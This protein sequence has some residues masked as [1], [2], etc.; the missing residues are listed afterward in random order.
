MPFYEYRCEKCQNE[1]ENL[2]RSMNS[3]LPKCP[4]CGS[5]KVAKKFSTFGVS[6]AQEQSAPSGCAGCPQGSSCPR[7]NF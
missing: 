1:F 4:K 6:T 7:A 5:T 3:P 2:A